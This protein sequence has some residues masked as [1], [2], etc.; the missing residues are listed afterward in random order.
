MGD[1]IDLIGAPIIGVG[2]LFT[3]G[4]DALFIICLPVG[5]GLADIDG[6]G[7]SGLD[8]LLFMCICLSTSEDSCPSSIDSGVALSMLRELRRVHAASALNTGGGGA[9]GNEKRK[10]MGGKER[11]FFR[12]ATKNVPT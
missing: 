1:S 5:S 4:P 11:Q 9:Q 7:L 6:A 8:E 3:L 12:V 2:A 10:T